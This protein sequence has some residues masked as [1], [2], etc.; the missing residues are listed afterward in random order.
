MKESYLTES[1][2][3]TSTRGVCYSRG[4]WFRV[5]R[6]T[7]VDNRYANS[8][9]DLRGCDH[10]KSYLKPFS[11]KNSSYLTEVFANG[12]IEFGSDQLNLSEYLPLPQ[13]SR[14]I[15]KL[16][17]YLTADLTHMVSAAGRLS[18]F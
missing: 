2:I 8:P 7:L 18:L 14:N 3:Q 6:E 9:P 13:Y 4:T 15:T 10:L 5:E 1:V 11:S 17:H 16:S 12:T